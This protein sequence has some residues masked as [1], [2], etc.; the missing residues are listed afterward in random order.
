[1]ITNELEIYKNKMR[2]HTLSTDRFKMSRLSLNF[3]FKKDEYRTPL[4]KL[5]L[6]VLMRG[7][8]KYPTVAEINK[9]LD[10][11]YGAAVSL[12]SI[13]VGDKCIFKISCKLLGGRFAFSGDDTDILGDVISIISDIVF[14]PL[15]DKNG[16]LRADYLES[17]KK[18]AIDALSAKINDPKSYASEQCS[19]HLLKGSPSSISLDGDEEQIRSFNAKELTENLDWFYRNCVLEGY[20][21]GD[22]D[23][24]R[25]AQ[26]LKNN[27]KFEAAFDDAPEYRENAVERCG[28]EVRKIEESLNVSQGRL[29]LG[30]RCGTVMS[31]PDFHAMS[32]FNEM[33]GGSSVSKLF[34]NVREKK[35]L[36]YYCYSSYHSATGT[37]KVGCGIRSRNKA[38]AVSEIEKQLDAMCRGEFTDT[39][40]ETAKR[41]LISGIKQ[42]SDSSAS[43]E[44]FIFRR[45]LAGVSETENEY[46]ERISKVTREELIM[47][48]NKVKLDTMYFLSGDGGEEREDE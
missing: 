31:D 39:E 8:S 4:T 17:E 16:L 12:R 19:K 35:S 28:N 10:E 30:Y 40:I 38:A 32:L 15:L 37:L 25:V 42:M 29:V 46:I 5:M 26:L 48:A 1:M 3:V 2:L 21:I 33:F 36:C 18:I 13:S 34:L 20:Y 45:L 23:A 47:A 27:F 7:S 44:A 24:S 41:T 14:A 43:I 22:E 9:A 11:R 6:S